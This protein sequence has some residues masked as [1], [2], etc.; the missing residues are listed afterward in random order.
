MPLHSAK[1][2]LPKVSTKPTSS[3][4]TSAP[5]IEPMP[6]ITTTTKQMIS[7]L[8]AHA[9]IDRGHRRRDHAGQR[10]QRDAGREHDA[11]QAPDVDAQAAHHVAV[12]GAGADHHA[13]PR[14][15]DHAVQADAPAAMHA[16]EAKRRYNG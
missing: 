14:A 3:D 11:V 2:T 12:A 13:Q 16:A 15:V 6:P 7:T 8:A 1:N 10:R 5:V 4:A 9:G